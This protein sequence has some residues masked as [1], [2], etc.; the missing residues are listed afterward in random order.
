MSI[1]ISQNNI[2]KIT[3]YFFL[4]TLILISFPRSWS[5]YP[6]TVFLFL[7]LII[8]TLDFKNLFNGLIKYFFK[9]V[10]L[11]LY[12]LI[13]IVSLL[14]QKADI[15]LIDE[16]LMF[17][18]IPVIGFPFYD[19]IKPKNTLTLFKAFI[20]GIVL[21]II[22]LI[23]R[24][25]IFV[26]N[27]ANNE[28]PFF[29]YAFLHNYWFFSSHFS[30]FE[31]PTYLSMK[32]IWGL[33]LIGFSIN[34]L[35]SKMQVSVIVLMFSITI[36]LLASKA[37]IIMW[38]IFILFF[39]FYFIR[40]IKKRFF[41]YLI[42]INFG[43][44]LTIGTYEIALKINRIEVFINHIKSEFARTYIDWKDL[45]QRT[46]EWYCALQLIKEKPILGHGIGRV[47]DRMVEEY[48]K[49]GWE[50]EARLRYNAHN[51][52][53]ETQMTFGIP[54]TLALIWM[55]ITP[56]IFR[57]RLQYPSL[58]TVFV[59]MMSFF[60]MFE[61]MFVRQWGIMFFT[62]FY[63]ILVF[64]QRDDKYILSKQTIVT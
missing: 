4:F 55:L 31:H 50:E 7:C 11:L 52:F 21:V 29:E 61:S 15:K 45:D 38:T 58:A 43:L 32:L 24:I 33:F 10:P 19:F 1:K 47:E 27:K 41:K 6:L 36:F 42:L 28:L 16:R 56:I 46:R 48:L 17:L 5:L 60:L 20:I 25:V 63:C 44:I 26:Y 62:L 3:F 18:L 23:I 9:I 37:G 57:K 34:G 53:L 30:F 64:Q 13:Q 35:F 12:F 54:G 2:Y 51:Q 14:I 22:T 49:N 59:V 8:W 40:K 39:L